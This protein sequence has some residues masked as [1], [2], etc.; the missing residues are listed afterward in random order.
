MSDDTGSETTTDTTTEE[1]ASAPRPSVPGRVISAVSSFVSREG[2]AKA[3]LQPIGGAGVRITLVGEKGG[4]LGDQVVADLAVAQAVVDTV[5][6]VEVAEWDRELTSET[7]VSPTH[8]RKMAG[9]VAGQK[10]FPKARN[11]A[12]L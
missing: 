8:Y 2:S 6:G 7:T 11:S 9:W 1:A 3:V 10:H 5:D 12:V 4:L